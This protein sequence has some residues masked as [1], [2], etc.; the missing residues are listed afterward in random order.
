M[1][2][3]IPGDDRQP[4]AD[5]EVIEVI[6]AD[7]G[8]RNRY[9]GDIEPIDLRRG[10]GQHAELNLACVIQLIAH[11]HD[12]AGVAAALVPDCQNLALAAPRRENPEEERGRIH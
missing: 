1:T 11:A 5:V 6:A 7:L 8:R 2:G 10:V 4:S 9:A 12:F 3:D